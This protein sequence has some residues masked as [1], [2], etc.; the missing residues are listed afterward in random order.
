MTRLIA[1]G[2][3]IGLAVL[4]FKYRTNEK[5]QKAVIYT[6][7]MGAASYVIYIVLMELIR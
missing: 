1:I 5:L 7:V 6:S 2:V 3:L 4:L